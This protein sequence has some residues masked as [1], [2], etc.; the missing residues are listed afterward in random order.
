MKLFFNILL[1]II[2]TV[3]LAV[4]ALLLISTFR[5][6]AFPLDARTVLTGSMEPAIPTGSVVFIYPAHE[7]VVGDIITFKRAESKLDLPITHRIVEVLDGEEKAFATKGDA[8]DGRD[9]E[10]VRESEIYGRVIFHLP[11]VGYLLDV[12]K[13]PWGFAAL[14]IIPA[15]LVIIDEVKKILMYIRKD[16]DVKE[17][18]MSEAERT[19]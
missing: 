1:S 3:F 10:P 17:E 7:Y 18:V 6:P 9:R 4:A 16:K 11:L 8:N 15:I 19:D 5:I 2:V 14:I 12:A 13:T